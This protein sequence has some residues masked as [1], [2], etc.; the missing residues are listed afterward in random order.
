MTTVTTNV[1]REVYGVLGGMGPVSSAEFLKTIYEQS[2]HVLDQEAPA[3]M[4][5]SD[6]SFPDRTDAFLEDSS[7]VVLAQLIESLQRLADLGTTQIVLCCMTIHYLLPQVPLP[8]RRRVVSLLDVI[9]EHIQLTG[10][11]HLLLCSIGTRRLGLFESHCRWDLAKDHFVLPDESDQRSI[12]Y[13][14]IYSLKRNRD[15]STVTPFV[16]SMLEKYGVESFVVGCSE[17]H[18]LAKHYASADGRL[19]Y[20]SLDPLTI[21]ARRWATEHT[22]CLSSSEASLL[23]R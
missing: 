19:G 5:Y 17:I 13:D 8:L 21:L 9:F 11:K 3:V 12:H 14:L 2:L 23:A 16:D 6:P 22:L 18:L 15:L 10:K 7:E 4:L 1:P 20:S